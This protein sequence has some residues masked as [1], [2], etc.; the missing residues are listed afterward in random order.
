MVNEKFKK[1]VYDSLP[2]IDE[3]LNHQNIPVFQRHIY[4]AIFFAKNVIKESSFES[5]DK[6]IKSDIFSDEIVPIFNDW[7]LETYGELARHP[8]TEPLS[9]IASSYAQPI[10]LKIPVIVSKVEKTN[11]TRW[12]T[13]PDHFMESEDLLSIIDPKVKIN[14]LQDNQLE[15]LRNEVVEVVSLSRSARLN[16]MSATLNEDSFNMASGIWNHFE[17]AISN[18]LSLKREIATSGCW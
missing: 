12:L 13:F 10:M 9:G 3:I 15:S 7:Y 1:A 5:N 8:K 2:W 17:K 11:E 16:L 4:A 14:K 6:L 18:I